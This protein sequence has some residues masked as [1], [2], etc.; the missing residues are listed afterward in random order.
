MKE[1]VWVGE[2]CIFPG[3]KKEVDDEIEI[4]SVPNLQGIF[5]RSADDSAA[6][7]PDGPVRS[8]P[9][10]RREDVPMKTV[11]GLLVVG[12]WIWCCHPEWIPALLLL[13]TLLLIGLF[14]LACFCYGVSMIRLFFEI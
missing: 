6:K 9:V 11:I 8:R 2:R 14:L 3:K 4:R 5:A 1:G 13:G 7:C 10:R 12:I